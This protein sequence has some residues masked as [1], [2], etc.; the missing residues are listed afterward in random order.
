MSGGVKFFPIR[1]YAM[2]RLPR[3][4]HYGIEI[5]VIGTAA[6]EIA[7]QRMTGFV[8]R[9]LRIDL[10]QGYGRHNL[11]GRAKAALGRE[12]L[13]KGP[14]HFVQLPIGAFEPFDGGDFAPTER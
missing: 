3:R 4:A 10:E 1:S 9:R 8:P 2:S 7:G 14:L 5:V 12:L 11:A 6:A 13:D